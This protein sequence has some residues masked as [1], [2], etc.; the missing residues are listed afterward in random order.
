MGE[1]FFKYNDKKNM[2]HFKNVTLLI[3]GILDLDIVDLL[4][5]F[6]NFVGDFNGDQ[7][8]N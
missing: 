6:T 4:K 8:Q 7:L 1:H 2:K 5:T 3:T